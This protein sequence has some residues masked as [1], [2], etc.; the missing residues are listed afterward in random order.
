[1]TRADIIL[2]RLESHP[3][4][5]RCLNSGELSRQELID[6]VAETQMPHELRTTE[7]SVM[8]RIGP[9]VHL[10]AESADG[11]GVYCTVLDCFH[12]FRLE[13]KS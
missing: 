7:T 9:H 5:A 4:I 2:S 13:V 8:K 3:V 11:S 6:M 10:L 1:V 12:K